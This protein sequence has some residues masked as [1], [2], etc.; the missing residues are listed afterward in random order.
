MP[1]KHAGHGISDD[2]K[3]VLAAF[4]EDDDNSRPMPGAK[5]FVSVGRNK[6]VERRHLLCNINELFVKFKKEHPEIKIC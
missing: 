5:D 4:Y 6:H 1:E 3:N 2:T